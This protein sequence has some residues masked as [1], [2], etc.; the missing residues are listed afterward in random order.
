M[1]IIR[2]AP[3]NC[4]PNDTGPNVRRMDDD[5]EETDGPPKLPD[6]NFYVTSAGLMR[7][8]T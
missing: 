1:A 7:L 5:D 6:G 4:L 8:R 2:I 3:G